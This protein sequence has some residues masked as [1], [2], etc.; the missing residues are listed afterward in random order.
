MYLDDSGDDTGGDLLVYLDRTRL[1]GGEL[2]TC[3]VVDRQFQR[4]LR[5]NSIQGQYKGLIGMGLIGILL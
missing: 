5:S 1:T 4:L 2:F 3:H